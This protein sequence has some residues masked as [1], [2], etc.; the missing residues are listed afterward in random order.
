MR[1]GRL[2]AS[3][4]QIVRTLFIFSGVDLS[5]AFT[6]AVKALGVDEVMKYSAAYFRAARAS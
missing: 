2:R 1:Y 5:R 3:S 4:E 6:Q